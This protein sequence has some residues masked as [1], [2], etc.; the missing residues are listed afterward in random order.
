MPDL[1]APDLLA[2]AALGCVAAAAVLLLLAWREHRITTGWPALL[3]SGESDI[4][5]L[6][7]DC[8]LIDAT[9]PA[10]E[11]LDSVPPGECDD[12]GRLC[13]ALGPRFSGFPDSPDPVRKA[14]RLEIAADAPMA[15]GHIVAEEIRGGVRV[16]LVDQG[17]DSR[18]SAA[19]RHRIHV[20]ESEL[21]TLRMA[22]QN[23]PQ[24]VWQ[25]SDA[26][27]VTWANSA[28]RALAAKALT[29]HDTGT[30]PGVQ[31]FDLPDAKGGEVARHRVPVSIGHGGAAHWFDVTSIRIEGGKMNY[32]ADANAV[33][34]AEIAQRNFVQTLA[35]TFAQLSTG[36]AIFDRGRQLALFNPALT[37]L[38]GLSAQFLS[39]RPNLMSFFDELRDRQMMPEP[40][41]YAD[42]REEISEVID[43]AADGRY[44]E[45]WSLPSGLTY[46]VTGRPHPDGAIAFL[47]E[48]IS[49][50]VASTRRYR[51]QLELGQSM[52][53]HLQ[54]AVAVFS[55][56]GVLSFCNAPYCRLWGIDPDSSLAEMTLADCIDHWKGRC[57][58]TPAWA[59]LQAFFSDPGHDAAW[60]AEVHL[61][62]GQALTCRLVPLNRGA[63]MIAF[64]RK[65]LAEP[66]PELTQLTG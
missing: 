49:A 11:L 37:D 65:A 46:R 16:N 55:P 26:D 24:P 4:C 30:G 35:K 53:N 60:Q 59:R 8:R 34:N 54:E 64:Q 29:K 28:Y 10:R 51:A 61:T 52:M 13:R 63:T 58:T 47:F 5:L 66:A 7:D 39:A 32:A 12:W 15:Q 17:A 19:Q 40:R 2:A 57:R 41:S 22:V 38:T 27:T 42:W 14:G 48:D 31:L 56:S 6:F 23:A 44:H 36:L 9:G 33:V 1:P 45:T 25:I 62:D 21:A 3:R 18:A 20:L 43:A 50:E